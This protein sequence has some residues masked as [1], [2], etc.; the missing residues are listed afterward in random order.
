[1]NNLRCA[2]CRHTAGHRMQSASM[3]LGVAGF[4]LV[5][6]LMQRRVKGAIMVGIVFVTVIAWIPGHGAS[7]F[8]AGSG[9]RGAHIKLALSLCCQW[10]SG[11]PSVAGADQGPV[12][13]WLPC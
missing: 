7:Y 5:A 13:A 8:G 12:T 10:L 1:M 11:R 9:I 3:W 6:V 2:L 4:L